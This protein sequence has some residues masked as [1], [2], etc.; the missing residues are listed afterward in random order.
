[1]NFTL[2]IPAHGMKLLELMITMVI[3]SMARL[4]ASIRLVNEVNNRIER[5]A[6]ARNEAVTR[7][8]RASA[9]FTLIEL[10]VTVSMALIVMTIA[11]PSFL[12]MVRNNRMSAY[13]N[14]MVSDYNFARSEAMKRSL[15][16][17]LCKRNGT[18]TACDDSAAWVSGWI[19]FA[20]TDGDGSMETGESILLVH[21]ALNGLSS[22]HYS[23]NRITIDNGGY[24]TG[25]AGVITF[26]DSRGVGKAKGRV[27]F[28]TGRL[29]ATATSDALTCP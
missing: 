18:S 4:I 9:G 14:E 1:M 19:V 3:P 10:I 15:P 17:T 28:N 13:V 26:C 29:S 6:H 22:I 2:K 24:A 20:D 21:P 7:D 11:I 27:L 16:V 25:Y 5:N 8:R 12:D 23:N